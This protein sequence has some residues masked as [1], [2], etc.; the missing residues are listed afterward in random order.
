[1]RSAITFQPV[2]N[3]SSRVTAMQTQQSGEK[4]FG[5]LSITLLLDEYID[6]FAVLIHRTPQVVLLPVDI[7]KYFQDL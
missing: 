7:D 2:R 3:D 4:T 1:M 5:R 6:D